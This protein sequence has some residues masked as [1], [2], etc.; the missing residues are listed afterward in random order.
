MILGIDASSIRAGG[1]LNHLSELLANSPQPHGF[2][3]VIVWGGRETL[4]NIKEHPWLEKSHQPRL[5][6]HLVFR[7][8]WQ[9][10]SL[11]RLAREAKCDVLF[12]PSGSYIGAFRPMVTFHQNLLPFEFR[13][14]KRFGYS[15]QTLKGLMLRWTQGRTF[16]R[17]DGVIFL[18]EHARDVVMQV[19]GS[20]AGLTATIPHGV[21]PRFCAPPRQQFAIDHYSAS[22]P[23]RLLYVSTVTFYKH[24]WH[25]VEAVARLRAEGVPIALDLVGPEQ[26]RP[27][28]R[29]RAAMHQ[30]DPAGEFVRYIGPVAHEELHR[31]HLGADAFVFA[32]SCET[33]GQVVTEAMSCGLPIACSNRSSMSEFLGDAGVYFDPENP[34]DIARAI[35]DLVDSPQRRA[36]LAQAAFDRAQAY[37][38]HRC[39]SETLAFL[40]NVANRTGASC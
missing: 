27:M 9:V 3:R 10:H 19:I 34:Q 21:D 12:V 16:R 29:L 20:T 13:E 39:A 30:F 22:R 6:Q 35:R 25:V 32:S 36:S 33:F 1:A 15:L 2:S 40:A 26:R 38:W 11:T 8:L 31:C 14:L 7:M 28:T 5:D 17:A 23:F 18:T 24:H 4:A 37:S